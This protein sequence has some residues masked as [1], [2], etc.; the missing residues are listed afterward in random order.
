MGSLAHPLWKDY[1]KNLCI[2]KF[3]FLLLCSTAGQM[4]IGVFLQNI[5]Y[6]DQLESNINLI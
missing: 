1:L 2:N 3:R 6:E 5:M 4:Q